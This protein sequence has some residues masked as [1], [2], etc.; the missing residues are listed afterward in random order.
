MGVRTMSTLDDVIRR[1]LSDAVFVR[2]VLRVAA[3]VALIEE[4]AQETPAHE[5]QRRPRERRHHEVETA[6]VRLRRRIRAPAR[7]A[8]SHA[9]SPAA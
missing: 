6:R 9:L 5:A 4:A 1:G 2:G 7:A 3:Q 8:Q